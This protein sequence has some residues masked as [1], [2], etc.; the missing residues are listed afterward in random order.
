M[1]SETENGQW[2]AQSAYGPEAP[3]MGDALIEPGAAVAALEGGPIEGRAKSGR[4]TEGRRGPGAQ[5]RADVVVIGA[6]QA[7]LSVGYHLA[8][9]G[10]NFV[11]L[12]AHARVGDAWRR[13]WDSLRLFTPARFDGLDGMPFPAPAGSFPTKDEM[14]DYLEKFAAELHLPVRTGARVEAV[15]RHGDRYRVTAGGRRI[16]AR[17]VVVAAASFQRPHLPAFAAELDP[18]IVQLHA[19]EYRNPSQLRAGDVLLVGAGNSGAEIAMDL[20]DR[21]SVWLAGR[22]VGHIPFRIEGWLGRHLM[23]RLVL[24]V[25]FHRVVTLDTPIGRRLQPKILGHGGPLLRQRPRDLEAAGVRRVPRVAGVD[26]GRPRLEDGRVLDVANVVWCTG[27]E[28]GLDW[29]E[30]PVFDPDGRPR[31]RRGIVES[32]PGL[33]FVGMHFQHSM[34]SGMIHG[35][36]RDARNVAQTVAERLRAAR[37]GAPRT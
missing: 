27:F 21:H 29:I 11:I 5:E 16:E 33:Y 2:R 18:A 14:A 30:L 9:R 34:S 37:T 23:V 32:E 24:R 7:G 19:G 10:V 17:Q 22:D 31:Q 26:A 4:P 20:A 28:P 1:K 15:S 36:G 6:G 12:D 8:R 35:V 13:R 25:L 3:A